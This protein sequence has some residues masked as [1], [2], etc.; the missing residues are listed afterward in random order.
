MRAPALLLAFLLALAPLLGEATGLLAP[1]DSVRVFAVL[2]PWLALAGLPRGARGANR[3]ELPAL[4]LLPL[5]ALAWAADRR[6]PGAARLTAPALAGFLAVPALSAAAARG[7]AVHGW[8]WALLVPVPAALAAAFLLSG[9]SGSTGGPAG[10]GAGLAATPLV[11]AAGRLA[12][13]A[14]EAWADLAPLAVSALLLGAALVE[15]RR[16]RARPGEAP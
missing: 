14:G 7:G 13:P 2:L 5:L 4:L 8:L 10:L 3:P 9:D 1:R 12:G 6:A 15:E 16:R 11:W